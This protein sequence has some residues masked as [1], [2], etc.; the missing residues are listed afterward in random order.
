MAKSILHR[1]HFRNVW[2]AFGLLALSLPVTGPRAQDMLSPVPMSTSAPPVP[3]TPTAPQLPDVPTAPVATPGAP[4]IAAPATPVKP[5]RKI[6]RKRVAP[7]SPRETTLSTDP[8]PTLL[9]ETFFATAKAS[10]RYAAIMD[11]GGW[12]RVPPGITKTSKAKEVLILRQ[13]LSVEGDLETSQAQVPVFDEAL[14]AA[15]KAF[16]ARHGLRQSGLVQGATLAAMNV[17]AATRFRQL[18]SSSQRLAGV[19][20][21]FADRYVVV[22]IPSASVEAVAGGQVAKRFVAIVGDIE[23]PSPEVIARI[24]AVNLNPTWT[25]PTSIIKNEIIPKMQ[26]NSGYLARLKIRV[27]DAHNQEVS[28]GSINWFSEQALNYTLRQDSGAGNSLGAIRINM[29]NKYSVYMHDTP[30]KRHFG[31]DY[32]FLSHGCVRVGGVYELAEWVLQGVSGSATGTWDINALQA[33]VATTEKVEVKLPKPIP[34]AWVYL[35]GWANADGIVN[36]RTDVY[37]FDTVGGDQA[38]V[39]DAQPVQTQVPAR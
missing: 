5:R 20:F 16:Q 26:K 4:A 17:P 19:N 24:Q 31:Q 21:S 7:P 6:A 12:P 3:A 35:T 9:P 11:A 15:V 29:P 22:N 25:V 30:G 18:A 2:T 10:E 14:T 38:A 37:N 1:F 34:V 23:H 28:P 32:R 39:P 33:V 27:L 13:R 36:F 8:T